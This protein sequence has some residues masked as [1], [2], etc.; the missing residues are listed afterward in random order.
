[1]EGFEGVDCVFTLYSGAFEGFETE[2]N[3]SLYMF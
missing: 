3:C 1:M 2:L